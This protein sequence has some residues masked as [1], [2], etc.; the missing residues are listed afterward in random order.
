[1]NFL[2]VNCVSSTYLLCRVVR[3]GA[4]HRRLS[5]PCAS[6]SACATPPHEMLD[7]TSKQPTT[8]KGL[9]TR[10]PDQEG[11]FLQSGIR[12][13]IARSK[14]DTRLSWD[15]TGLAVR[16]RRC[17]QDR[18]SFAPPLSWPHFQ[19]L[20]FGLQPASS[21]RHSFSERPD[22]ANAKY[23]GEQQRNDKHG[24]HA[25]DEMQD[26]RAWRNSKIVR[27]DSIKQDQRIDHEPQ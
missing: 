14:Q 13:P 5:M 22:Y 6:L 4:S 9:T 21:A 16:T 18:S 19:Q 17:R 8:T 7:C 27:N 26:T 3:L 25:G 12:A 10:P 15:C 23:T 1:M 11:F 24:N 2:L 20:V